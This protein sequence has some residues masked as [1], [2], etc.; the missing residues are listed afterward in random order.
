M[1]AGVPLGIARRAL[2]EFTAFAPAKFRP[3]GPGPIAE[4]GDVQ[5]VL[6]RAEGRLRSARAFVFEALGQL[7]DTACAGD[8]RTSGS[9]ASSCWRPSR[10]CGLR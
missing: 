2:D 3:P 10:R 9:V 5:L 7:W 1:L 4:D 8:V 6:T